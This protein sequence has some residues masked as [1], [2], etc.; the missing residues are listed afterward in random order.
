[1][2]LKQPRV[3]L[4]RSPHSQ[5]L[6]ESRNA[7]RPLGRRGDHFVGPLFPRELL[8]V[9]TDMGASLPFQGAE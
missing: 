3:P 8:P 5:L 1:M 4:N 7:Q 9:E 6:A 2:S